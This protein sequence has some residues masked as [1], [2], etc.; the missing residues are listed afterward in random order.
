MKNI[1][2]PKAAASVEA[3]KAKADAQAVQIEAV[4]AQVDDEAMSA[5]FPKAEFDISD[6]PKQ[7]SN[8]PGKLKFVAVFLAVAV[9][10]YFL[11]SYARQMM[12]KA[13]ESNE[14][15][16][17]KAIEAEQRLYSQL[18]E[19]K[20]TEYPN[21]VKWQIF[22]HYCFERA[23]ST[24]NTDKQ[25]CEWAAKAV[26]DIL[27]V[28]KDADPTFPQGINRTEYPGAGSASLAGG[29]Y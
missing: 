5:L 24:A 11:A 4:P 22:R 19:L 8:W 15:T 25:I 16:R 20:P 2:N 27:A 6:K 7:S 14:V 23:A 13:D 18:S 10:G 17:L 1:L 28:R 29:G 12:S 3:N 26:A 21:E 9:V